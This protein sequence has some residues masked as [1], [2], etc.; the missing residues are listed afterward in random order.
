MGAVAASKKDAPLMSGAL[1]D[2]LTP[3]TV[4]ADDFV[5]TEHLTTLVVIVPRGGEAEFNQSYQSWDKHVVPESAKQIAGI[6]DKE[7]N[8][9]WRVVMFKS[10][11]DNFRSS[12]R[13][14]RSVVRS[15][16]YSAEKY[17]ESERRRETL[18]S[19]INEQENKLKT[20]C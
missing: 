15:F 1:L 10:A 7:G 6:T 11:V 14:K 18:T 17:R 12:A 3:N 8:T 19:D 9:V 5:E 16:T 4:K 20:I 13:G 2:V